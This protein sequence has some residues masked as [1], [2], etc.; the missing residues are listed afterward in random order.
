MTRLIFTALFAVVLGALGCTTGYDPDSPERGGDAPSANRRVQATIDAFLRADPGMQRF[1]DRSYGFAIFPSVGKGGFVL[2][3][4]RGDG[5][6][7]VQKKL[8]GTTEL[9]QVTVGAQIGGQSYSEVIF[10]RDEGVV[11]HF[12][13]GG[14]KLSAQASAVAAQDGASSDADYRGGVAIF[15]VGNEGLMVEASVGGQSFDFDR[16]E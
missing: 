4:A 14:F 5:L 10:F 12:K 9:V 15:T 11:D 1:F 13:R 3:G 8:I 6:V 2:G 7:Y 16:L